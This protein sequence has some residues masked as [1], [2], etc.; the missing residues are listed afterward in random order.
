MKRQ[1]C[2]QSIL[3]RRAIMAYAALPL[4]GSAAYAQGQNS[5]Q[6]SI[7]PPVEQA[8]FLDITSLDALANSAVMFPIFM[9]AFAF[10]MWSATWL[11]RE[12]R[13]LDQRQ[14]ELALEN[15][16]LRSRYERAQ[17]L[18]NIP[19]QRIVIWDGREEGPL[20]RGSLP[21]IAGTPE[22]ES[23][24]VAFGT[25]MTALSAQAFEQSV[26]RLRK[27]A[28]AF[29]LTVESKGGGLLEAQ[30]RASGS[31]AFVRFISLSGDRAALAALGMA[32]PPEVISWFLSFG[33]NGCADFP[34]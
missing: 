28:E 25:W 9:G 4:L 16:D 31:H 18:L 26:E 3:A 34:K 22:Q 12:R 8:A 15:A 27:H 11:I 21:P 30:G 13:Q 17:A 6:T 20:C 10:A 33:S 7:D 23:A 24:F 1:K 32:P 5:T 2:R 19:D 29:D 14:G